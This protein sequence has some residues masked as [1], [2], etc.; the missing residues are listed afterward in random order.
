[1]IQ[2][3]NDQ[4]AAKW[5]FDFLKRN[6][7]EF[8]LYDFEGMRGVSSNESEMDRPTF[9]S[10][11]VESRSANYVSDFLDLIDFSLT[12]NTELKFKKYS[13]YLQRMSLDYFK[14][15]GSRENIIS[16]RGVADK[17]KNKR[18]VQNFLPL[19]REVELFF[20]N[21]SQPI[22][23]LSAVEMYNQIKHSHYVLINNSTDLYYLV[24]K[25]ID[26]FRNTIENGGLYRPINFLSSETYP[27]E[28]LLQKMLKL[29]LENSLYKLGIRE[30][31]I[32]REVN[33]YDDKRTDILVK[34]GFIGPIMIEL[35]LL[36]NNEIQNDAKR[37][38]YKGKLKRYIR[39]N[40][41]D[42]SF[43][44]VFQ[45]KEATVSAKAKY[46]N[47]KTEYNDISNL[48]IDF[49]NCYVPIETK[50]KEPLKAIKKEKSVKK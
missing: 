32:L 43:Y 25:A 16:I 5:R 15:L 12:L 49:I 46:E 3:F 30:M 37:S 17:H 23:I 19:L 34:Y 40:Y 33:L 13:E 36:D 10:C 8:L 44:L 41:S 38:E 26:D 27:N 7:Y 47:L 50:K 1:L 42:H 18:A 22:N 2:K 48:N 20:V 31:D 9:C 6:I 4:D 28:D 14:V 24:R 35:K 29:S 39:A 21:Q 45:R 11:F